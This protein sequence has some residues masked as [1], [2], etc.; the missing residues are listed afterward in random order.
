[1]NFE[2]WVLGFRYIGLLSQ[3]EGPESAS[4]FREM[5]VEVFKRFGK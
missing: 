2:A 1:M 3:Y 4:G 5:H